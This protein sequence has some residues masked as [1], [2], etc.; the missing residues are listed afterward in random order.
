MN[1]TLGFGTHSKSR[2][3]IIGLLMFPVNHDLLLKTFQLLSNK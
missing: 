1:Q 2:Q 3:K